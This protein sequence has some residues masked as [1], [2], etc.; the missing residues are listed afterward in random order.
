MSII[1]GVSKTYSKTGGAVQTA[2]AT[3]I[4]SVP[5]TKFFTSES[6]EFT[7]EFEGESQVYTIGVQT[8]GSD[9]GNGL[10]FY[11]MEADMTYPDTGRG[12]QEYGSTAGNYEL[13][14]SQIGYTFSGA[15]YTV[16]TVDSGATYSI[17]EFSRKEYAY[18]LV[19]FPT[20]S[21]INAFRVLS[22]K[23]EGSLSA[24]FDGSQWL[25]GFRAYIAPAQSGSNSALCNM[26]LAASI[27]EFESTSNIF[28][29]SNNAMKADYNTLLAANG[30]ATNGTVLP[31]GPA[32]C[33]DNTYVARRQNRRSTTT[34][35]CRSGGEIQ[36]DQ[37]KLAC[38]GAIAWQKDGSAVPEWVVPMINSC[39]HDVCSFGDAGLIVQMY[40]VEAI[41]SRHLDPELL[42]SVAAETSSSVVEEKIQATQQTTQ[43][44][45]EEQSVAILERVPDS[46]KMGYAKY[47]NLTRLVGNIYYLKEGVTVDATA[48]L[49]ARRADVTL[50][51]IYTASYPLTTRDDVTVTPTCTSAALCG[52]GSGSE[53]ANAINSVIASDPVQYANA[54]PIAS[55]SFLAVSTTA[56]TTVTYAGGTISPTSA[57][58][59]HESELDL[60][61]L[62]V[63]VVGGVAIIALIVLSVVKCQLSKPVAGKKSQNDPPPAAVG[64]QPAV[65]TTV[66][67][68]SQEEIEL[69][70]VPQEQTKS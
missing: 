58:E 50:T 62:I 45:S 54:T 63:G 32:S 33:Y 66:A 2:A 46:W 1:G 25:S 16:T 47:K 24:T 40:Q 59:T 12:T 7:Y 55:N 39:V 23:S 36:L 64:L 15:S 4:D 67:S 70:P 68:G 27:V 34:E 38:V 26:P 20:D 10:P 41:V 61:L 48:S 43:T 30:W 19:K 22:G 8:T 11:V 13:Q 49:S 56:T 5:E 21:D 29:S 42:N 17:N 9:G 60:Y 37:S 6:T 57:P 28:H 35:V 52:G 14:V 31:Q 65:D 69:T 53:L 3:T 44:I 18:T 51:T